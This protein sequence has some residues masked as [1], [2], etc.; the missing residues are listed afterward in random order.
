MFARSSLLKAHCS[1]ITSPSAAASTQ[2][3]KSSP[4]RLRSPW[5]L[6]DSVNT[7]SCNTRSDKLRRRV[8]RPFRHHHRHAQ[9]RQRRKTSALNGRRR[10]C[11][12]H[13]FR[14]RRAARSFLPLLYGA[15]AA[16]EF[17]ECPPRFRQWPK[18]HLVAAASAPPGFSLTGSLYSNKLTDWFLPCWLSLKRGTT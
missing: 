17:A 12:C 18:L 15:E 2:R 6:R 4:A 7:G 1:K 8:P 3:L 13:L 5:R 9:P 10:T 16:P 14:C 11:P